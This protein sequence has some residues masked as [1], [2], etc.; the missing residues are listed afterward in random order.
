MFSHM[1]AVSDVLGTGWHGAVA[2]NVRQGGTVV[3][4]GEGAVGLMR[5]DRPILGEMRGEEALAFIEVINTGH[6]GSISTIHAASPVL[7]LEGL[8]LMVMRGGARRQTRADVLDYAART[9]DLILQIG[10]E[11][12]RRGALEVF[13]PGLEME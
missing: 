12:G 7:A 4:V 10:R 9:I 6:P 13:L 8:A 5:P 11:G 3:V 2:A 1:P